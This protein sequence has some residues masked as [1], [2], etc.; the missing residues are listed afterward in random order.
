MEL[1]GFGA[2]LVAIIGMAF[3]VII[4]FTR[5][6]F[7]RDLSRALTRVTQQEQELQ[8]KADILEHRIRQMEQD[9]QA[10]LKRADTESQRLT[11]EAKSQAMNIRAAAIEEAKHRA[12][13]LMV[14]AEQSRAQLKAEAAKELDGEAVQHACASLRD[15]LP[16]AAL[17]AL[18][19][20]LVDELLGAL[21]QLDTTPFHKDAACANVVT[22]QPLTFEQSQRLTR[23]VASAFNN[24][25]PLQME[26]D[27][28]LVAGCIV[29]VGTTIV[30]N[31]L[32]NRLRQR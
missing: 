31:S 16:E 4:L 27:S 6:I 8:E 19:K 2:L 21:A 18:H 29:R 20:S 11:Q 1:L 7:A 3:F 26:T 14:E 10:K 28:A 15:L 22:A 30:D 9:Y 5:G 23:W 12:R 17:A 13:G 24:T 25:I 32:P